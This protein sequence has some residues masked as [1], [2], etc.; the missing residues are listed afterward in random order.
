[1]IRQALLIPI[2]CYLALLIEFAL[3]NLFGRWG[4]PHLLLLVVIFFNLY[5][6]IRYSLWAALW[7]GIMKDCFSTLPFGA[8]ILTYI[9]CAYLS[10]FIRYYAYE[11]G[12]SLSKLWMVL[13]LVTVHTLVMGS[14]HVMIFNESHWFEV[15]GTIWLPQVVITLVVALYVFE[16]LRDVARVLKF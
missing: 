7:A 14:V 2:I 8:N 13:C 3:S 1:M 6:G 12:S 4:D 9:A 16:K 5:S 15:L 11:R 10:T